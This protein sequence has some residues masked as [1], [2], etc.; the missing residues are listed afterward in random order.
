M[1]CRQQ[2]INALTAARLYIQLRLLNFG[3]IIRVSE[4]RLEGLPQGLNPF[5][6]HGVRGG[7]GASHLP[8]YKDQFEDLA[9]LAADQFQRAGNIRTIRQLLHGHLNENVDLLVPDPKGARGL[10]RRPGETADPVPLPPLQGDGP[11]LGGFIK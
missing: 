7:E 4:R 5:G 11:A 1:G 6:R 8:P 10:D 9:I 3:E 2:F